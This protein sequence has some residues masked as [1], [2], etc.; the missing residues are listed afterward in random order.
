MRSILK[1][2][3]KSILGLVIVLIVFFIYCIAVTKVTPYLYESYGRETIKAENCAKGNTNISSIKELRSY[4]DEYNNDRIG[5][6]GTFGDSAGFMNAFFSLLA[7][8]AVV[9]T[10]LYQY[11][12]D[13][14]TDRHSH[15]SQFENVFFN[16]TSTF[17][18]I[19]SHLEYI[20]GEEQDNLYTSDGENGEWQYDGNGNPIITT[21]FGETPNSDPSKNKKGREIFRYLYC[22]KLF[23]SETGNTASGIKEL[24]ELNP[25][26]PLSEIKD[27]V[28]DGTLD[29]YFRYAYR[30]LKYI[31]SCKLINDAEKMEYASVF[32]AQLSCYELLILFINGIEMDNNKFKKLIERYCL[33]NN[34]RAEM[35]PDTANYY[36]LYEP[37]IDS[38]DG[39][40]REGY[41][42]NAEHEYAIG[43]FCKPAERTCV[44]RLEIFQKVWELRFCKRVE[45]EIEV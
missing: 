3:G 23:T 16:M 39:R 14:K 24:I 12:K 13:G 36:K 19:V 6:I 17:E 8:A 7:F 4:G 9:F 30:I 2:F 42:E 11:Y 5:V 31:D 15:R 41:E 45:Q 22:V 25:D 38:E 37:K 26:M 35:L 21:T 40:E 34:L 33:F 43:A 32:R 28:F 20:E 18:E 29:H 27:Y 1:I 44:K 10:F